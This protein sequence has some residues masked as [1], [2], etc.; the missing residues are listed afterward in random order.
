M[1]LLDKFLNE[2][3][4]KFPKGYP[5]VEDK[6]EYQK[7][8][9]MFEEYVGKIPTTTLITE[10]EEEIYNNLLK[11]VLE[12]DEIP[13]T[14]KDYQMQGETF[15]E[16][17]AAEDKNTFDKLYNVAPPKK[18][19]EEGE[20]KGVGNGEV[21]LY[22][23]YNFSKNNDIEVT[24][25][26]VGDEPDLYFNGVGVEVKSYKSHNGKIGVGRFGQDKENLQLLNIIF[27]IKSL[28]EVLQSH[29]KLTNI[30]PT[31]FQGKDLVPAFTQV[32]ELQNIPDLEKLSTQYEIF[33]VINNNIKTLNEILENPEDENEAARKMAYKILIT[34]L[35]RKPKIGGY[36]ANVLKTGDIK[37]FKIDDEKLKSS[38]T[39]LDDFSVKQS[40]IYLDFGKTF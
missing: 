29:K 25:G 10:G 14:S 12:V 18:G 26:R 2:V 37:F 22:W 31:N 40:S 4:Y 7:L 36:L 34:K 13:T 30:N 9:S 3:S 17:V 16:K 6:K 23:L 28:S 35:E 39:L 11:R 19:E 24:I 27:G 32:Y 8:I 21:A 33:K 15:E 20:T 38:E 1:N 5:D